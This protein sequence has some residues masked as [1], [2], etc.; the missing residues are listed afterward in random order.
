MGG[1]IALGR[2]DI[3]RLH[4][5]LRKRSLNNSKVKIPLYREIKNA[6][7]NVGSKSRSILTKSWN[8]LRRFRLWI[9][10]KMYQKLSPSVKRI[11]KKIERIESSLHKKMICMKPRIQRRYGK[12]VYPEGFTGKSFLK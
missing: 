7:E 1:T 8:T 6:V 3:H 12:L 9:A 5:N 4:K 10:R 2:K 11:V